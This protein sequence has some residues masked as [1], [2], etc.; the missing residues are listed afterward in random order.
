MAKKKKKRSV[1][2]SLADTILQHKHA[3]IAVEEREMAAMR[4]HFK[5]ALSDVQ[6]EIARLDMNTVATSWSAKRRARLER[7]LINLVD[8]AALAS[9]N[10]LMRTLEDLIPAENQAYTG[11]LKDA[12]PEPLDFAVQLERIPIEQVHEMINMP[13]GGD[14]LKGRLKTMRAGAGDDVKSAL[15]TAMMLGESS[16]DAARRIR[17]HVVGGTMYNAQRIA[18]T[19]I[20]RAST[21]AQINAY[22]K[23]SDI[24]KGV[25]FTSTLDDR[26]CLECASLDG[27]VFKPLPDGS[28]DI[29]VD[30]EPPVHPM[31]RCTL[32]PVTKSWKELGFTKNDMAGFPGLRDLDGAKATMPRYPAW[33][34]RQSKDVQVSILGPGRWALWNTGKL[35]FGSA[36]QALPKR[37]KPLN[38][39]K[40]ADLRGLG[41]GQ[42]PK[43]Q[44]TKGPKPTFKKS[45][46]RRM[47]RDEAIRAGLTRKQMAMHWRAVRAGKTT[48]LSKRIF[49]YHSNKRQVSIFEA[50]EKRNRFVASVRKRS[51]ALIREAERYGVPD[52][53]LA[54]KLFKTTVDLSFKSKRASAELTKLGPT[55]EK[56]ARAG[57]AKLENLWLKNGGYGLVAHRDPLSRT[58]IVLGRRKSSYDIRGSYLERP[59]V[60]CP[61]AARPDNWDNAT[62]RIQISL[63]DMVWLAR[64]DDPAKELD[65]LRTFTHE[66]GH[67]LEHSS[68][69]TYQKAATFYDKR[70]KG[71]PLE[72]LASVTKNR[73]YASWEKTRKDNFFKAYVGK[74]YHHKDFEVTSMGFE[75]IPGLTSTAKDFDEK[76][77]ARESA[78]W[79]SHDP[80]H[81]SMVLNMIVGG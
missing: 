41:K 81:F 36:R 71:Q 18:R 5:R 47:V 10:D 37:V 50:L 13:L 57:L 15:E 12:L 55:V 62:D 75:Y 11:I 51:R 28:L 66:M 43:R 17:Q 44:V 79:V 61:R 56:E 65:Y 25:E 26:T 22:S 9:S 76:T 70:T 72:S 20:H 54:A 42:K 59:A 60:T 40:L 7:Q 69:S 45:E 8:A 74:D 63:S 73:N 80:E 3:L 78:D 19:E 31:C 21:M 68:K 1:N 53:K 14:T 38:P 4:R 23:H 30:A 48:S 35:S 27:R 32:V 58:A 49:H 24:I 29:P 67:A 52:K 46:I 2:Q 33:F 39:K 64:T 16:R 6:S 77:Y 34:A